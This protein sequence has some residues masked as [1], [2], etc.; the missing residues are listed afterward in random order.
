[1][2]IRSRIRLRAVLVWAL[3]S[4]WAAGTAAQ[5]LSPRAYW[6]APKGTK[7]LITGYS[8][9]SGDTLTDPSLPV[10]DVDSRLHSAVLGYL[11]TFSLW[12]R[13]A[14]IVG[15]LPYTWGSTKGF[16][17]GDPARRDLSGFSDLSVTLA[18]NLHGAPTMTPVDFQALR[19]NPHPILGASLKVRAPTGHYDDNKLI[20]VGANRWAIKPE[21]GYMIP[22]K[23]TWVLELEAGA[24]F[25]TDDDDFLNGQRKQH[26]I[27][28]AEI[29]LVKRI[30]PGFWASLEANYYAGG[31]QVIGG[32]RHVDI[33]RNSRIGGTV[34]FPFAGRHAIKVGF[35]R[36]WVTDFGNDFD[37]F[38]VS[39]ILVFR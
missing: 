29:H 25:F 28:A 30:R 16:L 18:V 26:P 24:W 37:Q 33:Q 38:L 22:L 4:L 14:N 21:L 13:T 9:S 3:C 2:T 35:S 5:E 8:Y 31:R 10:Y 23:P 6:P 32:N 11:Q 17:F 1:M 20:N 39:H 15:E 7:V 19:A 12:G 36:G 34:V 27:F